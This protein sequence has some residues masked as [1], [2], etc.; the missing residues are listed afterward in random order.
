M[1]SVVLQM[2]TLFCASSRKLQFIT[3]IYTNMPLILQLPTPFVFIGCL[4][5][6]PF[7][8]PKQELYVGLFLEGIKHLLHSGVFYRSRN[9]V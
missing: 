1:N 7:L 9:F 3:S 2:F 8:Y 4:L 6:D 5:S